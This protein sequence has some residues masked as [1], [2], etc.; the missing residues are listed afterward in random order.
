VLI[1]DE[2]LSALERAVP[3]APLHQPNNL[4]PIKALRER[5]PDIPQVACFDTAFHRD[6]PA[7][8]DRYAIPEALHDEGVRRYG[9]HGLSYEYVA[10]RLKEIAPEIAAGRVLAAHLG[11][12]ASMCA[13]KA[14]RSIDSTMGFTAL[15]GLPMGTRCGQIDPGVVLYLLSER[16]MKA[17]A[18]EHFLYNECGLKGLSG[19]SADVR[20]LLENDGPSARFAI[21]YFVYRIAVCAG[22]LA[23]ALGG[24]DAMVFTAGIGENAPAIRAAVA[25]RLQW[26]GLELD[27]DE[28]ARGGPLISS[29]ES[30]VTCFVIPT[31]EEVMIARH[32]FATLHEHGLVAAAGAAQ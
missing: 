14:G 24:I 16:R 7:V 31:D 11:S 4:A 1:D 22:A 21:D 30:R 3:F 18:V 2:V 27:D 19:L 15:D 29:R 10:T 23:S 5:A 6:H 20:D 9:F 13:I 17:K 28:N 32:T 8:A 25:R 12:G 26:L